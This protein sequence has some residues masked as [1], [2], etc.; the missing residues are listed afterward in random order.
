M[1]DGASKDEKPESRMSNPS[2]SIKPSLD[3]NEGSTGAQTNG[4]DFQR[5]PIPT[6]GPLTTAQAQALLGQL[7]QVQLAGTTLQPT[8]SQTL[9]LQVK[10]EESGDSSSQQTTTQPSL[11]PSLQ[12]TLPQTQLML[13]GGQITGLTLTTAQQQLLLQQAQA[14]LLAAAVQHSANQQH[15][16]TG[17]A[18][19]ATA[20]TP[21]AQIPI[22]QPIQIQDLQQLQ[23]LQQQ[24]LNLQQFVL[25]QPGHPITTNLQPTQFIISQTPQGQQGLVQAQN[26]LQQLPQQSQANL[27][28]SQ[29]NITFTQPATPTR[30]TIAT[31]PIQSVQ[32]SQSTPKRVDT[33][34]I[35]E[36]SDLEELEQF[37]KTFKQRRIKLG[38]TQG[39]VGLAMGKLYGNDFSQTTISRFEALNL[40]FK[41]MCKLKPLLEKW[42]NDAENLSVDSALS[43]PSSLASPGLGI[44]G[45]SRRRKKRTSIETN[46]R[47]ALEKSFLENQKPTS[48]EIMMIADQLQMEK[49]VIRVWFCNRRQKEKRINPPSS[50]S[51]TTTSTKTI[52]HNPTSM[53]ASTSNLVTSSTPTTL[54]V[55]AMQ[56]PA[57]SAGVTNFS[58]SGTT[59]SGTAPT[60]VASVIT[61]LSSAVSTSSVTSPS[62]TPSPSASISVT[63]SSSSSDANTTQSTSTGLVNPLCT[64]QITVSASGLQTGATALQAAAAQVSTGAGLATNPGLAAM[65]AAAGLA[66][67]SLMSAPQFAAGGALLSLNP[68]SLGG[69]LGPALMSNSTLATIQALAS[70]GTLPITSLDASGNLLFANAANP[71]GTPNIVT[72]P[73][74]LNPQNLSLLT[75]NPA[76]SLISAAGTTGH[77]AS[78]QMASMSTDSSQ[79]SSFT[80]TSAGGATN[81]TKAQ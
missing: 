34:N 45:L 81:T 30:T 26:L 57:S 79:N 48:E 23:Q 65:A 33:P 62:L 31:T 20:A 40:S 19:S 21:M 70:S 9:N 43:N 42:L 71:G 13:A 47:V 17:A 1:A 68:G 54:A 36:P 49:E 12:T 5:Q 63:E 55:N 32:Q 73:L 69:A 41:N 58:I 28:Q 76:V 50:N 35:E 18:I 60:N 51:G 52:F 80:V 3:G 53:V 38:F 22:T 6:G 7:H 66:N 25:V 10:S 46:V 24:N 64:S 37:A 11:Q 39:D 14:Q 15:N 44:E 8:A 16:T 59:A 4:L 67:P 77:A 61:G 29:P 78:L 74:F 72:A 27:L 2:E 75:S 56:M